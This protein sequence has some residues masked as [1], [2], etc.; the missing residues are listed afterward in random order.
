MRSFQIFV[1][2]I[3]YLNFI[4]SKPLKAVENLDRYCATQATRRMAWC[5][6]TTTYS[7]VS[8]YSQILHA[9]CKLKMQHPARLRRA[10]ELKRIKKIKQV[11]KYNHIQKVWKGLWGGSQR[12]LRGGGRLLV[13]IKGEFLWTKWLNSWGHFLRILMDTRISLL[14]W[15]FGDVFLV[16]SSRHFVEFSWT[17]FLIVHN[18]KSH[19]KLCH[20]GVIG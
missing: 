3:E 11:S 14:G 17:L 15:I 20:N 6:L 16:N 13:D 5:H 4:R 10:I 12:G 1:A 7:Y 19:T 2:F 9:I 18:D 8:S